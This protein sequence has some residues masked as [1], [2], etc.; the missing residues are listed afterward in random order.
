MPQSLVLLQGED[1][2]RIAESVAEYHAEQDPGLGDLNRVRIDGSRLSP[3]G[4]REQAEAMPFLAE[5]RIL[6]IDG[7]LA[8]FESGAKSKSK[9]AEAGDFTTV[10]EAAPP[11]AL[12][13]LVESKIDPKK[14]PI[15]VALP[16]T[17]LLVRSFPLLRHPEL[18]E[19]IRERA[20]NLGLQI[21][22]QAVN[23]L[24]ESVG[25]NLWSMRSELE[26]AALW[27]E[28]KT[29]TAADVKLLVAE[30]REARIFELVD[31]IV[32]GEGRSTLEQLGRMLDSGLSPFN[33]L[34]LVQN[35]VRTLWTLRYLID[36]GEPLP[37]VRQRGGIAHMSPYVADKLIDVARRR[38][39]MR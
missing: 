20:K 10:L 25:P 26:K 37:T 9:T 16:R 7:L 14:N 19:W 39:T 30:A 17:K 11:T 5:R 2:F 24:A 13:L 29:V 32:A 4:L 36:A 38:T 22:N 31:A 28:G 34:A 12:I 33:V 18:M 1:D 6:T 21:D 35:R 27:A 15:L 8:R 23:L 3:S